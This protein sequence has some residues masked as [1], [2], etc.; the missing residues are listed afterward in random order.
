MHMLTA[1]IYLT[2]IPEDIIN[3]VKNKLLFLKRFLELII[4]DLSHP[5]CHTAQKA[6]LSI[7]IRASILYYG[8]LLLKKKTG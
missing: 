4:Q 6:E 8:V 1:V 3:S 2:H 5:N 7:A